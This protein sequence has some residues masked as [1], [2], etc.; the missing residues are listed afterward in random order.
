VNN[1]DAFA[2]KRAKQYNIDT[3][4]INFKSFKNRE[5][6]DKEIIKNYWKRKRLTW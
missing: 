3:R 1:R 6:Y 2:L 4:Y 5:D